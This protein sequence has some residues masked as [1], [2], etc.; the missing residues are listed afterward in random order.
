M[1]T[2][3]D[4]DFVS[5]LYLAYALP[6]LREVSREAAALLEEAILECAVS[7]S[8][9]GRGPGGDLDLTVFLSHALRDVETI[10]PIGLGLLRQA[11]GSL[12]AVERGGSREPCRLH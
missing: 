4:D 11:I 2:M 12:Q 1:K 8:R 3:P 6:K 7:L 5:I 9:S 10:T